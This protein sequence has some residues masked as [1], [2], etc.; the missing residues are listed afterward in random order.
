MAT[1]AHFAA[2][3]RQHVTPLLVCPVSL[4]VPPWASHESWRTNGSQV[5]MSDSPIEGN[6]S[7]TVC[8][9]AQDS[10]PCIHLWLKQILYESTNPIQPGGTS[11]P[12]SQRHVQCLRLPVC[13]GPCF[14]RH[15]ISIYVVGTSNGYPRC[16]RRSRGLRRYNYSKYFISGMGYTLLQL[17]QVIPEHQAGVGWW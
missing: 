9:Y 14:K 13:P 4:D 11:D 2:P 6:E 7:G 5:L 3:H 8:T 15:T 10:Q 12:A 16:K 17:Y 1:V